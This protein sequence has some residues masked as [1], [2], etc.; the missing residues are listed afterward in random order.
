[1]GRDGHGPLARVDGSGVPRAALLV[2][3]F[4]GFVAVLL[5]YLDLDGLLTFLLNAVGA[6]LLAIWAMTVASQLRL[7][8]R[9]EAAG[10]LPVRMWAFPYLSWLALALLVGLTALMLTD[11]SSRRQVLATLAVIVVLTVAGQIT[12]RRRAA[13]R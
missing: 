12:G 13:A 7:R 1:G 4:F 11:G 10:P 2:S 3:V 5:N 9:L 8:R 6:S